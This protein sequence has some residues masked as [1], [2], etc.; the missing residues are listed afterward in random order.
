[1]RVDVDQAH[2]V[3]RLVLERTLEQR[4]GARELAAVLRKH[5][6]RDVRSQEGALVA[7]REGVV[8]ELAEPRLGALDLAEPDRELEVGQLQLALVGR[9]EIRAR[10]EVV[11]RHAELPGEPAQRLHRGLTGAGLDPRD[12]GIRDA[13]C[14]ELTLRQTPFQPQALESLPDRLACGRR[15]VGSHVGSSC[16]FGRTASMRT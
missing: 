9:V 2:R 1:L 12:V 6:E 15:S 8:G 4:H 13:G 7:C 11:R 16:V 10:L 5:G 3:E 14:S